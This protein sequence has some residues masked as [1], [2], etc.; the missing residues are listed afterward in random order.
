MKQAL[1]LYVVVQDGQ[2]PLHMAASGRMD[3][4]LEGRL[5]CMALLLAAK[6]N[7]ELPDKVL[8]FALTDCGVCCVVCCIC[9]RCE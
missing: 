6:A 3:G 4:D 9:S 7:M 5:A 2:T 8:H 1:S